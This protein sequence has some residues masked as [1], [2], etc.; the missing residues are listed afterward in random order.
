MAQKS[1][2]SIGVMSLFLS[3]VVLP[4]SV[5]AEF[6]CS[7]EV[8][9]R[10]VKGKVPAP[11]APAPQGGK[12]ASGT[13]AA[14]T[15]SANGSATA[16]GT[17]VRFSAIQRT[18]ADEAAAKQALAAEVGRQK[19]RASEACKRDHEGFAG[20]MAT[21]M[22]VKASLLNS[23]SFSARTEL[24]KA[25]LDECREQQ[26]SCA[27]VDS[28]EPQ[29]KEVVVAEAPAAAADAKKGDAKKPDAKKK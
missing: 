11:P 7:S 15:P 10:W 16:G 4:S 28:A 1:Y 29:C 19:I 23:L 3:A 22:S 5:W 17:I 26:G 20:C 12:S 9:Y 13:P 6:S 18:G 24:E 2:F 25:I 8:S 21:N 14:T 27:S